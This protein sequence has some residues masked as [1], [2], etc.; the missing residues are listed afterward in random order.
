VLKDRRRL[1]FGTWR[2]A[3]LN[4]LLPMLHPV[5]HMRCRPFAIE[6]RPKFITAVLVSIVHAGMFLA[7][8]M[9]RMAVGEEKRDEARAIGAVELLRGKVERDDSLP[10]PVVIGVDLHGST[11][12][13]EKYLHL[14]RSFPRLRTL[15]LS[16]TSITDAGMLEISELK[17]LRTLALGETR[18]DDAGLKQLRGMTTLKSLDLSNTRVTGA[19]LQELRELVNLTSLDLGFTA[20]SDAGLRQLRAFKNLATLDLS[21]TAITDAGLIELS[22][23]Q[24]LTTLDLWGT[25]I[26]NAGLKE[27]GKLTSLTALYLGQVALITDAGLKELEGLTNLTTLDLHGTKITEAGLKELRESLPNVQISRWDSAQ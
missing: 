10:D 27:L 14:L 1:V 26:T 23:L 9:P 17:D 25:R 6:L 22:D 5:K 21:N 4:R 19:G 2:P 11:R 15:N 8:F 20:V 13:N 3:V 16:N 24:S 18:L 12:L 7:V